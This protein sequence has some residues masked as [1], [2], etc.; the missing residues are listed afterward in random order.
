ML[1]AYPGMKAY[2]GLLVLLAAIAKNRMIEFKEKPLQTSKS[3]FCQR[4]RF[5]KTT[6]QNDF[7]YLT[8]LILLWTA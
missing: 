3:N 8:S 4:Y 6:V 2:F 1:D 5:Q 7:Q